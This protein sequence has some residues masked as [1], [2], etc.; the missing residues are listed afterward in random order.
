M[1]LVS[2]RQLQ[3]HILQLQG[4]F[5]LSN[6]SIHSYH[7]VKALDDCDKGVFTSIIL[8]LCNSVE[9]STRTPLSPFADK[10]MVAR[11]RDTIRINLN[12]LYRVDGVLTYA[13]HHRVIKEALRRNMFPSDSMSDV[14]SLSTALADL[15]ADIEEAAPAIQSFEYDQI[16]EYWR[17][18]CFKHPEFSVYMLDEEDTHGYLTKEFY[19]DIPY[20]RDNLP[21]MTAP[22]V[23]PRNAITLPL[24]R[25]V[26]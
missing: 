21:S 6:E 17:N 4:E 19:R 11:A 5:E 18:T 15:A 12:P 25:F 26:K 24:T 10:T 20:L 14:R 16:R 8:N 7:A 2:L 23:K 9:K 3:K 13:F 22:R 1:V